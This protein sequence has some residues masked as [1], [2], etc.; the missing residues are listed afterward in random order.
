[1]LKAFIVFL[2]ATVITVVTIIVALAGVSHR[3]NMVVN[4]PA[5][6]VQIAPAV[7]VRSLPFPADGPF[8]DR[9]L[10]E[11]EIQDE[12]KK[13]VAGLPKGNLADV[14]LSQSCY[15]EGYGGVHP[16]LCEQFFQECADGT[17]SIDKRF[18]R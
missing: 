7:T 17:S 4:R 3:M 14:S 15:K 8:G 5:I 18:C 1:M 2:C 11:D 13:F 6:E 9:E 12:L 16:P 10:T